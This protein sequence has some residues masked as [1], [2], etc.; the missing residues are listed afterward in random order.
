MFVK[1]LLYAHWPDA[2]LSSF[3]F[4]KYA[5]WLLYKTI[6]EMKKEINIIFTYLLQCNGCFGV[7][8]HV[9]SHCGDYFF[10]L[11][12]KHW[13]QWMKYGNKWQ[14]IWY[15]ITI[16]DFCCIQRFICFSWKFPLCFSFKSNL[17]T[18]HFYCKCDFH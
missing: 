8:L 12:E 7:F 10:Y 14:P 16:I 9:V 17:F 11:I 1:C 6:V 3:C 13:H 15:F 4:G 5:V 2:C 18:K